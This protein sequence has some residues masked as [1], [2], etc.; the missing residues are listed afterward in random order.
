LNSIKVED[1][2]ITMKNKIILRDNESIKYEL[3]NFKM[4]F[5][6]KNKI[7]KIKY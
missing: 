6:R 3:E 7:V 4:D 2:S 1:E 5:T